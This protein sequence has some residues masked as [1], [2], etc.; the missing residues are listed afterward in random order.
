MNL[1]IIVSIN[2]VYQGG[3][4]RAHTIVAAYAMEYTLTARISWIAALP[5]RV[6][7]L[8]LAPEAAVGPMKMW[9][10]P[11]EKLS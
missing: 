9:M 8:S 1:E 3:A 4:W 7:W 6:E 10:K 5:F 11:Y 2:S